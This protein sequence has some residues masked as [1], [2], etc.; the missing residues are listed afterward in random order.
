M[1][2]LMVGAGAVGGYFGA[3]L[4]RSG[5]DL[6]FLVR[7]NTFEIIQKRGLLVESINGN[8]TIHPQLIKATELNEKFDLII[9]A[10]K[11]YDLEEVFKTIRPAI[12]AN[13]LVMTLQNGIDT[14]ERVVSHFGKENIIAGVAFITSKLIEKG[15][16]GHFKR[17]VITIGEL[18]GTKSQRLVG[19]HK[20]LTNAGIPAFITGEIMKKKWEKLCWNAT[21]NPLS[22]L[23]NG[24]VSVILESPGGLSA[25]RQ[26][27]QEI[28]IVA[29]ES[30]IFLRESIIEDT[31]Q[32]SYELRNY[33]TSMYEDW[34]SG[35]T[36]ENEYLNGAVYRK[37]LV[38]N[39][40]A[41]M[42]FVLYQAIEAMT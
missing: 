36:T 37:G 8:M 34:K 32:A 42:N 19:I 4:H 16:I 25:V 13:T 31:V 23:M 5:V 3:L 28:I 1:K 10:V 30:G 9:L 41:P 11:C 22:V 38:L 26:G 35:K 17:G 21:F 15:K 2:I 7:E 6:T 27:I 18:T 39:I 40:P 12:G 24:P 33:H 29:K 14:E 20:L